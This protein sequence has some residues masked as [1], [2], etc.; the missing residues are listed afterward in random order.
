MLNGR[1]IRE[2][3]DRLARCEAALLAGGGEQGVLVLERSRNCPNIRRY[4]AIARRLG[5]DRL[6]ERIDAIKAAANVAKGPGEDVERYDQVVLASCAIVR[7]ATWTRA[8]DDELKWWVEKLE[9]AE[10]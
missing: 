2:L 9:A 10:K 7:L 6:R 4:R 3:E 5:P 8:N 1:K